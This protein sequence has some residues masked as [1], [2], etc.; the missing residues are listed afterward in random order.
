MYCHVCVEPQ[1]SDE[2]AY[3][4]HRLQSVTQY[5]TFFIV[6]F[7]ASSLPLLLSLLPSPLLLTPLLLTLLLPSF[8]LPPPPPSPPP[9]LSVINKVVSVMKSPW[10]CEWLD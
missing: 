2:K 1:E 4:I 3:S 8:S 9:P 5:G 7:L 10:Q 6:M